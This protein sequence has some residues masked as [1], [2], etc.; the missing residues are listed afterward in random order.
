MIVGIDPVGTTEPE[1][2]HECLSRVGRRPGLLPGRVVHHF[3][4]NRTRSVLGRIVDDDV[5]VGST[6]GHGVFS[7]VPD[8]VGHVQLQGKVLHAQGLQGKEPLGDG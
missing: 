6:V 4:S 5:E 8:L 3:A 1:F 2:F 7:P